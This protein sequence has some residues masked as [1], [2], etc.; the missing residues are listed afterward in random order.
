MC[1]WEQDEVHALP[2]EQQKAIVAT[3]RAVS[4]KPSWI[5]IYEHNINNLDLLRNRL[6][7]TKLFF[8][9]CSAAG[10]R[11]STSGVLFTPTAAFVM[12]SM[13]KEGKKVFINVC[14]S[15]YIPLTDPSSMVSYS[16]NTAYMLSRGPRTTR[17][18]KNIPSD[19]YDVLVCTRV[20]NL[21]SRVMMF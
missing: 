1:Y 6:Y 12:K 17:D 7:F 3:S 10:S 20:I 16:L 5:G 19:V 15:D 4:R 9:V 13:T 2:Q 14:H 11:D 8:S 18:N 21:L